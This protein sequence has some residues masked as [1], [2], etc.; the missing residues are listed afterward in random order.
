[1]E[2]QNK[3]LS[4]KAVRDLGCSNPIPNYYWEKDVKQAVKEAYLELIDEKR[5]SLDC[6]TLSIKPELIKQIFKDKFGFKEE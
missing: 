1:M 6:L 4:E 3:P 5:I 2:K